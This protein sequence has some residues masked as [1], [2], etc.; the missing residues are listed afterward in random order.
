M[1]PNKAQDLMPD[2]ISVCICTFHREDMLART[3]AGVISQVADPSFSFEIVVVDNDKNHSA[4]EIVRKFQSN[5]FQKVLY[6]CEP[7]QN[8]ALARN[9]TIQNATGNLIAFIDDDEFPNENWLMKMYSCLKDYNADAVLGPVL[10]DFPVG[11]PEWLKKSKLCERRRNVTGS[12]IT[13]RDMRTGNILFKRYVFEKDDMWFDPSKGLT[14]GSDVEFIE[15]QIKRGRRFVWCDEAIVFETVPPER[16]GESF[17]LRRNLRIGGLSG[18]KYR[19][20][21]SGGFKY[22]TRIA[23]AFIFYTFCLPFS[24]LFG[25]HIHIKCLTKVYYYFGCMSGFFGYVII[26]FR[27]Y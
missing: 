14:G 12:S 26:R 10:P 20:A 16:W 13:R 23:I 9:R 6:D 2:H 25:K 11:V 27:N 15:R 18:E 21:L 24:F 1:I 5:G 3:L 17:Y 4:G 19:K 22:F 7:I 8:I